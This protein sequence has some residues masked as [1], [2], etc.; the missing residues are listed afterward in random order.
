MTLQAA[1]HPREYEIIH[2]HNGAVVI[3]CRTTNE[4]LGAYDDRFEALKAI[5]GDWGFSIDRGS[6]GMAQAMGHGFEPPAVNIGYPSSCDPK[7]G[8]PTDWRARK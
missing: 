5:A 2:A 1:K 4:I 6:V 7:F 3:V 8:V